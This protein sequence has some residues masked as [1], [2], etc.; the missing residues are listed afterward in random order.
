MVLHELA[1][2]AANYGALSNG[3]GRVLARWRLSWRGFSGGTLVIEWKE[4]GGL[5]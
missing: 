5:R 3:Y 1:T 4:T 2:I